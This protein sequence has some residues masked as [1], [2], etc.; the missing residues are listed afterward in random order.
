MRLAIG[1]SDTADA[2][3]SL[4]AEQHLR[5]PVAASLVDPRLRLPRT[6][7]SLTDGVRPS[8]AVEESRSPC[9]LVPVHEANRRLGTGT[10]R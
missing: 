2:R 1:E 8:F 3:Y 10:E 5:R 9:A 7:P 6:P 4:K